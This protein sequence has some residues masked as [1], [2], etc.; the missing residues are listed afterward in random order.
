MENGTNNIKIE[1]DK[2]CTMAVF[3]P[4]KS[5]NYLEGKWIEIFEFWLLAWNEEIENETS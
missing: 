4:A 5:I 2:M 1:W 3:Q